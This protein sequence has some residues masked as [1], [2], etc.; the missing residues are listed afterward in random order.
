MILHLRKFA[1]IFL[2]AVVLVFGQ[3]S[4]YA[5]SFLELGAGARPLAMGSAYLGLSNDATGF[6]WNPAGLA[7]LPTMQVSSMYA[8]LFNNLQQQSFISG[9]LPIFGGAS[10]AVSWMRLSVDDIPKFEF[11]DD[12]DI[13]AFQRITLKANPLTAE[14]VGYFGSHDD[15]FIITFAKFIR[16][17]MDLGWQ[18]FEVPVDI[19]IGMNFKLLKQTIDANEASGVG[20]DGGLL[21]RLNLNKIFVE[22]YYGNLLF[23]VNVQDLAE[24]RMTWNTDSKHHDQIGR[25]FK[26]GMA[27]LQPLTF[28]KSQLALSYDFDTKYGGQTHLGAELWFNSLLAVRMGINAGRFTAGAGINLWKFSV[29][30]AFQGHDLGNSHRVS[31]TFGK[32]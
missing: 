23:G 18:Y 9:A 16:W 30:Y 25:N 5:G 12:T 19:G 26:I 21:V 13:N 27:Y 8:R 7:F 29:D 31:L 14:P 17:N 4:R 24:T 2:A 10:V 15:A 20:L 32:H 11:D 28:I 22:Q 3:N 6:Y 1:V